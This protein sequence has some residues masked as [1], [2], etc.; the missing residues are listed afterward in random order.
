MSTET[1]PENSLNEDNLNALV[2]GILQDLGG[3]FSIPL[4]QIGEILGLYRALAQNDGLTTEELSEKTGLYERYLR[5]W[6][7]AQ[8]ASN[9]ISFDADSGKF[10]MSP[11]QRSFSPMRIVPCA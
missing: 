11:E 4:V 9:Y 5:E 8:A 7:S 1:P 3:A 6:L 2:G 10:S